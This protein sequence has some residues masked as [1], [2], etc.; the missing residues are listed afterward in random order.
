MKHTKK[1]I[2]FST[3]CLLCVL[4]IWMYQDEELGP[5]ASSIIDEYN[6]N[7]DMVGNAYVYRLGMWVSRDIEPFKS[8]TR[9][10]QL[11]QKEIAE[12][13]ADN[14]FGEQDSLI[15]ENTLK[16]PGDF[17]EVS[18]LFCDHAEFDCMDNIWSNTRKIPVLLDTYEIFLNRLFELQKLTNFSLYALPH[19]INP[20]MEFEAENFAFKL[21]LLKIIYEF[22]HGTP[23]TALQELKLLQSFYQAE[24]SETRYVLGKVISFV[25]LSHMMDVISW[26]QIQDY[27]KDDVNWQIIFN[28]LIPITPQQFGTRNIYLNEFVNFANSRFEMIN[29]EFEDL[30]WYLDIIPKQLILKPNASTNLYFELVQEHY[31]SWEIVDGEVVFPE[32]NHNTD[33]LSKISMHNIFGSILVHASAPRFLKLEPDMISLE[34]KRRLLMLSWEYQTQ[35][36]ES[37]HVPNEMEGVFGTR[38]RL[39]FQNQRL[40]IPESALPEVCIYFKM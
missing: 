6:K 38:A 21:A 18:S 3:L 33:L 16:V 23:K 27:R 11:L 17:S 19:P 39:H 28:E 29:T 12:A 36:V 4:I 30:P 35:G 8:G 20:M 15:V 40:C 10:L 14:R 2:F 13:A 7:V 1:S 5:E 25:H 32:F 37:Q 22:K 26:L 31:Y 34:L 24:F 9:Q